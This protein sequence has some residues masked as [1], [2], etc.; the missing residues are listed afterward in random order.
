MG[1]GSSQIWMSHSDT[2]TQLPDGAKIIGTNENDVPVAMQIS[3]K[4][5]GIQFHPEVT[6]SHEG[7]QV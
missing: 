1:L 4:I 7:K 6:H 3:E 2:C 5:F